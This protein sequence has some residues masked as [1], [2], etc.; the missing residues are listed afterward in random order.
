VKTLL[1]AGKKDLL[2]F[3][4]I[5]LRGRDRRQHPRRSGIKLVFKEG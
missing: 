2:V 1:A 5:S 3:L 4:R